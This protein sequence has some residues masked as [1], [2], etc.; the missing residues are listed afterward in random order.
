M[1]TSRLSRAR[2]TLIALAI[3]IG[4]ALLLT[5][6]LPL[7]LTTHAPGD[8]SDDPAILWNLWWVRYSLTELQ[9]SPF[10]SAWMFYPLGINLVFYTLTMLNGI[11]SIPI[12]MVFGIVPANSF[13]VY[14]E[15]VMAA[16]GMWLFTRRL[17]AYHSPAR[18]FS[19]RTRDALALL[20]GVVFAYSTSKWLYLSLGQFNIAS[21]HWLPW[22]A[23]YLGRMWNAPTLPRAMR[24]AVFCAFFTLC[25]GWTEFTYASFFIQ[26]AALLYGW[27]ALGAVKNRAWGDLKRFTLACIVLGV[28]FVV[29]MS[30]ILRLMLEDMRVNGDFLVEGLGFSDI[31]S[32]DLLGF[33]IPGD[34]HPL[35]GDWV[36]EGFAFD[37][38]NFAFIGWGTLALCVAAVLNRHTRQHTIYWGLFALIFGVLSLG[39]ML[40]IN[41]EAWDLPMPF[42]LM[43]QIPFVKANRYPSRYTVMIMMCLAIVATWGA[44]ALLTWARQHGKRWGYGVVAALGVLVLIEHTGVPLPLSDY[45]LPPIYSEL[46][47]S[48]GSTVLDIPLAWRNG[49]RVTGTQDAAFMFAQAHQTYHEKRMLSGNTSRNPELK[50]QYFTELPLINSLLALETGKAI[51]PSRLSSDAPI[52]LELLRLLDAPD[53]VVQQLGRDNPEVT[54]EL[55]LPYL[56]S[57]M[58]LEPWYEDEAYIGLRATL[59]ALPATYQWDAR[60]P[61]ARLF[62]GEGWSALPPLDVDRATFPVTMWV[63]QPEARLLL[64]SIGNPADWTLTFTATV[65][66]PTAVTLLVQHPDGGAVGEVASLTLETGTQPYQV[67]I[68][69]TAPRAALTNLFF[70]FETP[71]TPTAPTALLVESAALP[72]GDFAHIYWNGEDLGGTATGYYVALFRE[73]QLVERH[74]FDTFNEPA[75]SGEM[76]AVLNNA[77]DGTMV[78]IAGAD[79][80][81]A[82]DG[83]GGLRLGDEVW[84]ALQAYGATSASDMRGNYAW[85]HAFIGVKGDP[86]PMREDA[87]DIRPARVYWGEPRHTATSYAQIE[88]FSLT[89]AP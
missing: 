4:L 33:V 49:F 73:G 36:R 88:G 5:Y 38:L 70:R 1:T 58:P 28:L 8:G 10:Q 34:Q 48:A 37:Y 9:Q 23:L 16:L 15:L 76:A 87:S 79:T 82:A 71:P 50:F 84:N 20:A 39:P 51:P 74:H 12:Q 67:T 72:I 68:P 19:R 35:F 47:Q 18:T 42:D 75:A 17:L 56:E 14:F 43:L 2:P 57:V 83:T 3:F 29:G 63:E 61:L 77:P 27:L 65:E 55:T 24:E 30:P 32:N 46:R 69:A 85:S 78:A 6:P 40:R 64:P 25:I 60:H 13:V 66:S 44:V 41:G 80:V 21:S 26:F 22:A 86:A 54:P 45:R 52:S 59:P 62:F 7:Q 31:F 53:I 11:L 81:S 89:P